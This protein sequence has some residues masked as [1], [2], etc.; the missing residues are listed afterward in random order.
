MCSNPKHAITIFTRS[1]FW[2]K[3]RLKWW[4]NRAN[5]EKALQNGEPSYTSNFK[6]TLYCVLSQ[7]FS[8][9]MTNDNDHIFVICIQA[10][11]KLYRD[12]IYLTQVGRGVLLKI[13]WNSS[14]KLI[15]RSHHRRGICKEAY[16]A[17]EQVSYFYLVLFL[18]RLAGNSFL[19][20][21]SYFHQIMMSI[22]LLI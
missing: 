19:Q 3:L 20:V 1:R 9:A 22:C 15:A 11:G 4:G 13:D 8:G 6:N 14:L 2:W 17:C 10:T 12:S 18:L 5:W 7:W 21:L 16:K